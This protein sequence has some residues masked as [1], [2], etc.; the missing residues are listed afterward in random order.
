MFM[1]PVVLKILLW[2]KYHPRLIPGQLWFV[3]VF[4]ID[5]YHAAGRGPKDIEH[6]HIVI[7]SETILW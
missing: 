6:A 7:D 5:G 4:A 3:A 2:F 1:H